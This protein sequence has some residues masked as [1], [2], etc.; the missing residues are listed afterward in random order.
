MQQAAGACKG[1]GCWPVGTG[2]EVFSTKSLTFF[3]K[4]WSRGRLFMVRRLLEMLVAAMRDKSKR[5]NHSS[6]SVEGENEVM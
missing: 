5:K 4:P 6:A 3:G 1:S 2:P